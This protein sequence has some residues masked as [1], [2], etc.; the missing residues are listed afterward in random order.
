MRPAAESESTSAV[1]GAPRLRLGRG[2]LAVGAPLQRC[3]RLVGRLAGHVGA[4]VGLTKPRIIE[5]LLITTV[6]AMIAAQRQVPS[7]GLALATLV[8]GTLAAGRRTP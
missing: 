3:K 7:L 4:Y 1:D 2:T 8:G 6:P 5:L